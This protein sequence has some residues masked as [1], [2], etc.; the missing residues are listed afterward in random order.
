MHVANKR[1]LFI[2]PF[3]GKSIIFFA[4]TT[5]AQGMQVVALDRPFGAFKGLMQ[6]FPT[7]GPRPKNRPPWNVARKAY[8]L[9]TV[10][11]KIKTSHNCVIKMIHIIFSI[12]E[13]KRS[14]AS[15]LYT[16]EIDVFII[17]MIFRKL[18][19]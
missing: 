5:S 1:V 15:Y 4:E 7:C 8:C 17:I 6:W 16:E 11:K 10:K 14:T 2:S 13:L 12:S 3:C 19:Q 9:H 18:K